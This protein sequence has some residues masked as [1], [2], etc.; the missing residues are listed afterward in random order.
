MNLSLI[1]AVP[2]KEILGVKWVMAEQNVLGPD[3][4]SPFS[5]GDIGYYVQGGE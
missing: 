4:F 3:V 2:R 1:S 5:L